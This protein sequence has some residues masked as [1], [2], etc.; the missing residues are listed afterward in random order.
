M[1]EKTK[2]LIVEDEVAIAEDLLDIL[3]IA[4]YKIVGIAYSYDQAIEYLAKEQIDLCFLD[5]ALKGRESGLDVADVINKKY[6]IPFIFLTS[7]NEQSVVA[8]VVSRNPSGYLIKP[9][10]EKDIAPAVALAIANERLL[11]KDIFP[12][13]DFINERLDKRLSSQ[14]YKVLKLLWQGSKNGEI[15][16]LL[17]VSINTIKTHVSKIYS[18]LG[19]NSRSSAINK[20]MNM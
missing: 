7:F 11:K 1:I 15:A 6:K 2:I 12:D 20:V 5:V 3:E 4:G 17:F 8:E 9:F 14:E 18:K 10:K 19:A 16:E 13:L